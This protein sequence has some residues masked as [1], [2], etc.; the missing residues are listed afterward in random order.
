MIPGPNAAICFCP[1]WENPM[2]I[3][4]A[5]ND[6]PFPFIYNVMM[7]NATSNTVRH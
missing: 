6:F 5:N 7:I 3:L 1:I 2:T 4:S